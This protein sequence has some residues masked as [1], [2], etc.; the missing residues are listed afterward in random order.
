MIAL[1]ASLAA[2]EAWLEK[3]RFAVSYP[4]V[5]ASR[6]SLIFQNTSAM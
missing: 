1:V 2:I 3:E 6:R 4:S 5:S